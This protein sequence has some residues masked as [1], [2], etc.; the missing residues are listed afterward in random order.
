MKKPARQLL[1]DMGSEKA[2]LLSWRDM[3]A[4]VTV[5]AGKCLF[6]TIMK[7]VVVNSY[8]TMI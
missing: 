6:P 1:K 2:E 4:M 7:L 8:T 5:K 3:W